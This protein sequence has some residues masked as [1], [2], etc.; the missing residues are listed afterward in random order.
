M[1]KF[2][3]FTLLTLF[4]SHIYAIQLKNSEYGFELG[5]NKY[6]QER[7]IRKFEQHL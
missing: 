6:F 1:K 2:I 3:S 5:G 4:T 7:W